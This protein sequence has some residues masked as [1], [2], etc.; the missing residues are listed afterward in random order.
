MKDSRGELQI[1]TSTVTR[2]ASKIT[3]PLGCEPLRRI[4]TRAERRRVALS[5]DVS[6]VWFFRLSLRPRPHTK[7]LL[8]GQVGW[9]GTRRKKD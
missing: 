9:Y 4:V 8:L 6:P 7:L 1:D 5:V 3:K 2:N